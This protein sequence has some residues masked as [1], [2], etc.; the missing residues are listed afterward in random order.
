V[1]SFKTGTAK[2]GNAYG[3][4]RLEDFTGN[5]EIPLFGKDFI[6][7]NRFGYANMYLMIRGRYQPRQYNPNI[8]DFRISSIQQ[9]SD[10]KDGLI[11]KITLS[12]PISDLNEEIITEISSQIKNKP[13]KTTIY[14]RI[15]DIEKQLSLS[16]YPDS[17]KFEIDKSFIRFLEKQLIKFKIN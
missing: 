7:Y 10:I 17:Q 5:T 2:N 8:L 15:E 11:Q 4:F 12:V 16:L 3:V 9:L 1:T 6:E 13:G 14:F